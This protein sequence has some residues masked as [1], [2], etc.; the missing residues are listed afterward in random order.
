MS[1]PWYEDKSYPVDIFGSMNTSAVLLGDLPLLAV[2]RAGPTFVKLLLLYVWRNSE[3]NNPKEVTVILDTHSQLFIRD[4]RAHRHLSEADLRRLC[5]EAQETGY[6]D[7]NLFFNTAEWVSFEPK[8]LKLY[9]MR[10]AT[11]EM[12]INVPPD[13][14]RNN[15]TGDLSIMVIPKVVESLLPNGGS[16]NTGTM[17]GGINFRIIDDEG[18]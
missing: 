5:S 14:P 4:I 2:K 16:P 9:H 7:R 10:T 12:T 1:E 13:I 18:I 11:V 3:D 6:Y 15:D 17:G 8:Q